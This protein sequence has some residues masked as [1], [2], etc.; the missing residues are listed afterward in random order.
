MNNEVAKI[1]LEDLGYD[2][3]FK[4]EKK[5]LPLEYSMARVIAEYKESY[6]VKDINGEYLAKITGK[7]IFN[8]TKREDYPAVG[9]WV[10][11]TTPNKEMAIIHKILPRKTILSKKYS[12]KQGAQVIATNIDT[13]FI[14]ESVDRDYNLNRFER[15][16]VLVNEGKIKPVIILNKIDLISEAELNLK[17]IQIK[18]RFNDIDII[19]T[20]TINDEGLN[21]LIN[22]I[23]YGKTYCFLGSSGVGKSSLINKLLGKEQIKTNEISDATGKGKHTTT[24]REIYFLKNGGI[25]IDNPGTREVGIIDADAGIENVFDEIIFLSKNCKYS[26]CTHTHESGCAVLEAVKTKKLDES[27]YLNY[28]KLKKETKYYEMDEIEKR[29]KDR[30]FGKFIKRTLS[31]LK[32]LEQ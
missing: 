20:S 14:V 32:D 15:Y 8:A 21:E 19:S 1:K 2:D 27:K 16:L 3:F 17:I 26:D 23:L 6:R 22:Y 18:N 5:S 11:I 28:I 24:T 29:E 10:I 25:V 30:K 9:D 4:L 31:Q 13:A 12:N 7:Q